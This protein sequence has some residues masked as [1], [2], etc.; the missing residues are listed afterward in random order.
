MPIYFK[1]NKA[2]CNEIPREILTHF[3]YKEVMY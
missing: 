2:R 1:G 3:S